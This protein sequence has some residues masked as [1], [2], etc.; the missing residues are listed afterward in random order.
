[1]RGVWMDTNCIRIVFTGLLF[2]LLII[3]LQD[4]A[5]I[6]ED[7]LTSHLLPLILLFNLSCL[8]TPSPTS[9]HS[10]FQAI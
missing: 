5:L 8:L 6:I 2:E 10:F 1:M 3:S 7:V 4:N 9:L